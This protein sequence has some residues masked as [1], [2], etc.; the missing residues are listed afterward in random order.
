VDAIQIDAPITHGSSG[1]P[2]LDAAGQV[3]GINA[4]IRSD[5]AG[6]SGIGFAVPI[7]AA[8]RSLRELQATGRVE[9][10]YAGLQTE[11]L[12]PSLARRL[13]L[14][15]SHG[16]LVDRVTPKGPAARAGLRG[17]SKEIQFEGETVVAGGDVVLK[18]DG[19]PVRTSDDLVRIVT[20][21]LHP[22]ETAV[23]TVLRDGRRRTL[24]VRLV[25]RPVNPK[26]P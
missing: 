10:A 1:G 22:R 5:S 4:Q 17:G 21:L 25:A 16:A 19:L 14:R 2:L 23:F 6:S 13:G 18:L 20:N 7:D 15:A 3:I 24:A 8:R 9:Y 26:Q 11:D 12:T